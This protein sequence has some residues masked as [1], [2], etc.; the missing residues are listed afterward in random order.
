MIQI[1]YRF[2]EDGYYTYPVIKCD[3]CGKEIHDA[4]NAS[5]WWNTKHRDFGDKKTILKHHVKFVHNEKCG[6]KIDTNDYRFSMQLDV[7]L[8]YLIHSVKL[9]LKEAEA[10]ACIYASIG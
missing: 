3:I 4:K 10:S 1:K 6:I 9:N 8:I 5:V 2:V 7:F